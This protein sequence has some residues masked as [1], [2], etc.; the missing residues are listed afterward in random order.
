MLTAALLEL[1]KGEKGTITA[2]R[3]AIHAEPELGLETPRT[4]EKVKAALADLPL[5]WHEGPSCTGAVAILK[6]AKPGPSVLLRGDMDALPMNEHTDLD[7]ASTIAGRMHACG[8]DAH[9]AMLA[10]AARILASQAG[11][12][13]GE[14]RF[15]FQPGEEGHHGARFMLEDGLLGGTSEYPL[16]DA[17][18]ALH[19]WPNAPHGRIEGRNGPMLASADLLEITVK[20][21]GGHASMPHDAIDP[22]PVGAEIVL[23]LQ[24]MITRR[25][26]ASEASVITIGKM[27]AGTTN[28]IIPDSVYLLGTMRNLSAERREAVKSAVHQLAENIAKAHNCTAE[29]VITPGFPPTINDARAID[30]GRQVAL[31]L[32]GEEPWSDRP[33]P[34]MGAEDFSYVLEKVPGAMFF[35]GVAAEGADWKGCCGLHSSRMIVD[36][37]VMPK[38]AAF[39]A[40]CAA[41]FLDKGW[42]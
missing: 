6:G 20:G 15:M 10:G 12:L 19:V 25:F 22:V 30:L 9:T 17:A 21:S 28:N 5:S 4:L 29:V 3:R 31:E 38:G 13:A 23:A 33:A 42:K 35:L 7:F 27:D 16:P 14:V 32:G 37:S 2:L 11:D 39:L 8:H 40:G 1:A 18:F 24:T 26:N 34:T 36:E 41:Q